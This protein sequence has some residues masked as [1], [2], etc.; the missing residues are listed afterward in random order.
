MLQN[1]IRLGA[2]SGSL[3]FGNISRGVS[4]LFLLSKHLVDSVGTFAAF[5]VYL[6][7]TVLDAQKAKEIGLIHYVLPAVIDLASFTNLTCKDI[8]SRPIQ[9]FIRPQSRD[10]ELTSDQEVVSHVKCITAGQAH[11]AQVSPASS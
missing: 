9:K 5:D 3:S 6:C 11:V 8:L 4:P 2:S 10:L 7:D 1:D